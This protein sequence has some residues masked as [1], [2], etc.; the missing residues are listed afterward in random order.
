MSGFADLLRQQAADARLRRDGAVEAST[1]PTVENVSQIASQ[2]PVRA[3]VFD[4]ADHSVKKVIAYVDEH[5]EEAEAVYAAEAAG[6][7]RSSLL[8]ALGE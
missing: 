7:A 3:S 1:P 5:P 2:E 4:P 6:K 8:S